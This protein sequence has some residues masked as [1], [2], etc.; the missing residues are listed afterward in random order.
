MRRFVLA[1]L[2]VLPTLIVVPAAPAYAACPVTASLNTAN[3]DVSAVAKVQCGSGN[4]VSYI[5]V[6]VYL[7][8]DGVNYDFKTKSC[9]NTDHC[10]VR[11]GPYPCAIGT[12]WWSSAVE[13][14]PTLLTDR[15][16]SSGYKYCSP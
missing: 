11:V 6:T 1:C 5:K 9:S 8:Q 7:N 15:A 4:V 12:P 13:D 2:L 3:F 16:P 14:S 10:T